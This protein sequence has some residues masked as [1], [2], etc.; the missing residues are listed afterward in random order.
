M[1]RCRTV[2]R[3]VAISL[4]H[5]DRIAVAYR[6][7]ATA[8]RGVADAGEID[9]EKHVIAVATGIPRCYLAQSGERTEENAGAGQEP[10]RN[11]RVQQAI[12]QRL[13]VTI[14]RN[15]RTALARSLGGK[16]LLEK[17]KDLVS[18]AVDRIGLHP[19]V[20]WGSASIA[21]VRSC[22]KHR[23]AQS[24]PAGAIVARM[25]GRPL[26]WSRAM[27][28]SERILIAGGGI[29]G[30][31][32]ATALRRRGFDPELVE[33]SMT[34]DT[35]GAGI[36]VQPNG[37]R[38]L[39]ALGIG[40]AVK[41]LGAAISHWL[42]C[43]HRGEVLCEIDLE[44]LWGDVGVFIGIERVRLQAAL[45]SAAAG[46]RCRLGTWVAALSQL[47]GCVSVVFS[48]GRAAEYDLVVGADGISSTVRRLASNPSSPVYDGQM[49]WRSIAQIG[50]GSLQSLQFWLGDGCFFGLCPV[51]NGRTY[52]F[53]NV[54]GPRLQDPVQGRLGR[55]RDRFAGFGGLV[56]EYLASLD[57]DEQIHC[58]P[59][60]W[61]EAKEWRSG[62]VV[63]IGDAAH[64]SSPM[65]GQGGCMAMEDAVVLAELLGS[66]HHIEDALGAYVERRRPRVDWV[67]QQSRGVGESLGTPGIRN[68]AL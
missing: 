10:L 63:L 12:G 52:G 62:R 53:G 45:R 68:A 24:K 1:R 6:D 46:T 48:D 28:R 16:S 30:L 54:T 9:G 44:K 59:V 22:P 67:G 50:P 37:M 15:S 21:R 65:M 35:V 36:A 3:K 25:T 43:D 20:R 4:G 29:A 66:A 55:L 14:P 40:T 47:G 11:L 56:Q 39:L 26:E 5:N 23:S 17:E 58:G 51:G 18:S 33:R 60:E 19:F 38:A 41:H 27:V 7:L 8:L 13:Q 2:D 32:L 42:F 34:W 49:A 57:Q 31:T 64:A 61:L